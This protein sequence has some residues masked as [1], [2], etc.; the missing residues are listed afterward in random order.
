MTEIPKDPLKKIERRDT[1]WRALVLGVITILVTTGMV[2]GGIVVTD[3]LDAQSKALER[4]DVSIAALEDI[5]GEVTATQLA[6]KDLGNQT[7]ADQV[8]SHELI[9]RIID[10]HE[11]TRTRRQYNRCRAGVSFDTRAGRTMNGEPQP[12]PAPRPGDPP[13]SSPPPPSNPPPPSS[14]PSPSPTC[15]V[16][17]PIEGRCIT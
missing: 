5:L 3:A 17:H 12:T 1:W 13:P 10:C 14:S 9:A 4:Q 16:F 6:V 15:R 11:R 8:A 7:Y 2:V